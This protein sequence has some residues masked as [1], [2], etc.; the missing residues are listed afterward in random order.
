MVECQQEGRAVTAVLAKVDIHRLIQ[1]KPPLVEGCIN[2]EE[3]IQPNGIDLTLR[4]V[5]LLQSSGR[6][7]ADK[8]QR[9]VS[10]LAPLVFDGLGFIDLVAGVYIITYN[11]VVHL[12]RDVMALATPRSSLLRCGVTVNTAVWDAGYSGRSQSLMVVYNQQGFRLQRNVRIVQLVFLRLTQETEG[13][14]GAYQ[15]EN[16]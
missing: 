14:Q 10:S 7:A 16:T 9:L 8:S 13:Y 1:G 12:P 11:E 6:I 15:G 2:L 5:A 4:E 3:Q